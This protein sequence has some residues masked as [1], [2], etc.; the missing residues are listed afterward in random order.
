MEFKSQGAYSIPIQDEENIMAWLATETFIRRKEIYLLHGSA[1]AANYSN[2]PWLFHRNI[3]KYAKD[4]PQLLPNA[5][6]VLMNHTAFRLTTLLIPEGKKSLHYE[7]A[8][9]PP[10]IAF[11]GGIFGRS[12]SHRAIC[13]TCAEAPSGKYFYATYD[14]LFSV[15]GIKVC[16]THK[17]VLL[18][19][20]AKC[21]EKISFS[22]P[23]LE[24]CENKR[25]PVAELSTSEIEFYA[26]VATT[27]RRILHGA[28]DSIPATKIMSAIATNV[29]IRQTTSKDPNNILRDCIVEKIGES[30]FLHSGINPNMAER[31]SGRTT[32]GGPPKNPVQI[33]TAIHALFDDFD[34]FLTALTLS[35]SADDKPLHVSQSRP[36][37]KTRERLDISEK[38][39]LKLT[40]KYKDVVKSA[41]SA[42][43][44]MTKTEFASWPL[45]VAAH[46]HARHQELISTIPEKRI[47]RQVLLRGGSSIKQPLVRRSPKVEYALE[48]LADNTQEQT[49]HK[50]VAGILCKRV[51]EKSPGH[52][53]GNEER[54]QGLTPAYLKTLIHFVRKWLAQ[55]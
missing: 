21:S 52:P 23:S 2:A 11:E 48:M 54:Y 18:R 36:N 14:R 30:G 25:V 29:A 3:E 4:F 12:K 46:I 40:K 43:P 49:L 32:V 50:R 16:P 39:I 55:H 17:T 53:Y 26:A 8:M 34:S 5:Q 24:C 38:R 15:P 9:G 45:G 47:T 41:L 19:P 27:A 37:S 22:R 35:S 28:L 6:S 13:Q 44:E 51:N 31:I 42:H 1:L 7:R 10:V 20:C 33:V